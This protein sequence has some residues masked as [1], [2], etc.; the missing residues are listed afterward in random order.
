LAVCAA[1]NAGAMIVTE[2]TG[3]AKMGAFSSLGR[4]FGG[5]G[6]KRGATLDENP[7][8]TFKRAMRQNAGSVAVITTVWRGKHVGLTALSMNSLSVDPP[9]VFLA[10]GRKASA[11]DAVLASK[12]FAA[13]IL[14]E[15]Q[16]DIAELFSDESR[17]NRRFKDSHWS[18]DEHGSPFIIGGVAA[19]I[20]CALDASYTAYTHT[21]LV[22]LA[23]KTQVTG[24]PPLVYQDGK[25]G[26]M[27]PFE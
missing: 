20:E 6:S 8:T 16:R 25:F 13:N 26:R 10:V 14:G 5:G 11:H 23:T 18:Q 17:R 22:G 24:I 4:F 3:S 1:H 27:T 12:K 2:K 21:I 7:A 15:G 19:N 9:A